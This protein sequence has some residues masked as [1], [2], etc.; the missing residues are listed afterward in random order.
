MR[1]PVLLA[2]LASLAAC[3][4]PPP[5]AY[6]GGGSRAAAE[7]VGIGRDAAGEACTQ[8][9]LGGGAD[10]FCGSWRHPAGHVRQGGA[11]G[12]ATLAALATT[13]PWRVGLNERYVC[14]DPV[15][16]TIVGD[17]PAEALSC[18]RRVGSWPQVAMVAAVGGKI[19]YADSILPALP[20]LQRSIGV[21]SGRVRADAPSMPPGG[22]DG[23]F[24]ARLAAQAFS[25]GDVGQ[26]DQLVAAGTRANL[27]ESYAEAEQAF[28]AALA[29]QRKAL[30]ADNP[31]AATP[32]TYLALQVSDLGRYP[33]AD[34]LLAEA[35]A[36]APRAADRAAPA[37]VL[38]YEALNLVNQ[39]R[40]A[41][42]L[43]LLRRAE[44]AYAA[45]LPPEA[46]AQRRRPAPGAGGVSLSGGGVTSVLDP[47][48]QAALI[49]VLETRRYEA[50]A[51]RELGHVAAAQAMIRSAESLAGSD[52]VSQPVLA[53]RLIRTAAVTSGALGHDSA[54]AAGLARSLA[55]FA[56]AQPGTRPVAQTELLRA[57]RLWKDGSGGEALAACRTASALLR[58]LKAGTSAALLNPCLQIYAAEADRRPAARQRILAEMFEASQLAQGDTTSREIALATARLGANARDPR[59][60]AAIRRREDTRAALTD[61]YRKREALAAREAGQ[62]PANPAPL[63]DRA[64]L[65]AGIR[66]AE[67]QLSDADAALQAAA[68]NYG[69][70]VQQVVP[71]ADVLRALAPD[72]AFASVVLADDG[73]WTFLLRGGTISVARS[74]VDAAGMAALVKQLR[75]G[76]E[77]TAAGVPRFD[78]AAAQRL[79]AETL[80]RVGSRLAGASD[81]VAAPTGPLLSIPFSVLLTGPAD[82]GK[83]G[84]AP[85]LLRQF[86]IAQVPAAANFV[87]LRRVAATSRATRPW[88]GLGDFR[89][90]TLAQAER[91]FPG[92]ACAQSARLLAGLPPL[93][94]AQREL[95]AARAI[96]GG[97]P[98]DE[99]I[100]VAYTAPQVRQAD[101]K[102]Y[103]V[104]HFAS[105]A[106][107]PD[108]LP[109]E[110]EPTIIA[111][112]PAGAADASGARLTA[113]EVTGL[114][115]DAD[116]VILSA[117]NTGGPGGTG[118]ESLSGLARAFFYA[119]ARALMVTQWSVNDQATAYLVA[120]TLNRL[121]KAGGEGLGVAAALRR[122]QLG[123]LEAAG[124]A[125]P[126]ELAH[127]FYWAAFSLIGEGRERDA[128]HAR[129][130]GL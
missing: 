59:V 17:A 11:A 51:E 19:Y 70:L 93:P 130:A 85:W 15:A 46:L 78:T 92:P 128:A 41:E 63:P 116:V 98:S 127:P 13:S 28:R 87:S 32:L 4:S 22:A 120:D 25:A 20:V 66:D 57:A 12:P 5:D 129:L 125:M 83:L 109:C 117:C 64:T 60:G 88:F 44:A 90:P 65:D 81:L 27:A 115:L 77:P 34:S 104:L 119:G 18:T 103:R 36:L 33:E 67:A 47:A 91:S 82:A 7:A 108:E 2:V 97:L 16:T 107:L 50:I 8:Q 89:P 30:G 3:A 118:G 24:A 122:A 14:G 52:E 80:G 26:Y 9:A 31:N 86:P 76:I 84:E 29:L 126:A 6:W 74:P 113:S 112:T 110:A 38:N 114:D 73:T 111:S 62:V 69:Q 61:L 99:L 45:L 123:M 72:E 101:L 102:A 79:Y 124:K 48:E 55:D 10:I 23:L 56:E 54:A 58:S 94:F 40:F 1:A 37:R 53:A 96:L 105:H 49:G 100:G 95:G 42:A 43:P 75:A 39:G 71:A 35:A 21:L 106:L 68:P 121:S